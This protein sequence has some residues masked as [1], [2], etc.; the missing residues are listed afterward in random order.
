[1]T[2]SNG[3]EFDTLR[4]RLIIGALAL[5]G[6]GVAGAAIVAS[7]PE[8]RQVTIPA[9]TVLVAALD[10]TVS[11]ETA[12]AGDQV[13]LG[14]TEPVALGG[15]LELPEGAE[16]RGEV[17]HAR[18]G[19][20][21]AGAPELTLRFTELALDGDRYRIAADPF[22]VRG[23]SDAKESALQIAGG[24]VVGAVVGGIAGD[25]AKGAALGA[26]LGTGVALATEGGHIVL[27]AGQRLRIRLAEPVTVMLKPE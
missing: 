19:G 12:R 16:L 6:I 1:M 20:R 11:T 15:A 14:T 27:P 21:I 18:G 13:T 8:S 24:A 22:R 10:Q 17:T 5:V 7:G 26:V 23:A 25:A 4:T 9:G 3:R 2:A